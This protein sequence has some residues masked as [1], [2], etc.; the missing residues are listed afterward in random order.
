MY[1]WGI[2]DPKWQPGSEAV[3]SA[4]EMLPITIVECRANPFLDNV[5][6]AP[7]TP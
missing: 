1:R 3:A 2:T 4:G 6:C 7:I 5:T